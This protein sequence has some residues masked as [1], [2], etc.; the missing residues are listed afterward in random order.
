MK[1]RLDQVPIPDG[2][3]ERAHRVAMAAFAERRPAPR[4][5]RYWRPVVVVV[6]VAA[7]VGVLASPPG[8]SVIQSIREAVG[9][10]H[11]APALFRLPAP[12]RLLVNSSPGPWVVQQD[13]SKRLLGAYREASWSP[14]GRYV[15]ATR[16]NELVTMEPNGKVHWTLARPDLRLPT[17]GGNRNDTRIA[18]LSRNSLRIVAGDSTGD[19]ARC[20]DTIPAAAPVWQPNSLRVLAFTTNGQVAVSDVTT[21][22]QLFRR[23]PTP[24]KLQWSSDGRLLLAVSPSSLRVYDLHGRVVARDDPSDG[25]RDADATFLPGSHQ[26]V[27]LRLHGL[28]TDA[29]ML[30]SGK[31]LFHIAGALRQ[32]VPSP[33]GRWLLLTFPAA[34]QWIFVST[35]GAHA[36]RAVSGITRQFGSGSFPVVAGWVGK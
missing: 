6:A 16:G 32:V 33:D 22:R 10:K 29:F 20:A 25:T 36:I 4:P 9:V 7:A 2:A 28:Q 8:R 31:T 26:V 12:G 3:E 21:C 19:A 11:A 15:V 13:G 35:R 27:V 17:W 23:S 1:L 24:T 14:F 18:Y 30:S 34:D 5:R